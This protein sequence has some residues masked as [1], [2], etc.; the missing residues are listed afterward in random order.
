MKATEPPP[1]GAMVGIK[2]PAADH[3]VSELEPLTSERSITA[4]AASN[5]AF[6]KYWG[7]LDLER[8]IPCNPS[9]SMTLSSCRSVCSATFFEGEGGGDEVLLVSEGGGAPAP[10]QFSERILA[11][12][13]RLRANAGK[14]GRFRIATRNTFP[15]A[16]GIASSASGFTALSLAV[17]RALGMEPDAE[18][19][20]RLAQSSG[21]GSAS[22]SAFG[23][24]VRWPGVGSETAQQVADEQHWPLCDLVAIVETS[25]KKVSSLEGHRRASSSPYFARRQ[26]LLE[27]RLEVT[28]D[29]IERRDFVQL[30]AVVEE[31]AIDLHLIAM[32]SRPAVYYW[33][34]G[35][36][37]VLEAVRDLRDRGVAAFATMDA[38]ANVHVLC[39]PE[40]VTCVESRLHSLFSVEKVLVDRVGGGP[41]WREG[42]EL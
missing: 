3:R 9:I 12:L 30:G 35:T 18:A 23:G 40:D 42:A 38:G 10:P 39:Q 16:A 36:L 8:V 33:R 25:A 24:Y 2:W 29:A 22:R 41:V 7:A 28:S 26:E 14:E 15:S 5:I 6:I 4:E 21:S 37:E 11:H 32:S 17:G 34:P 31:E 20:S 13:D 19:L 27:Q 1:N